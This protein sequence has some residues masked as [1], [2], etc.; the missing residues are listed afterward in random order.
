MLETK[1]KVAFLLVVL[2]FAAL[3]IMG[4]LRGT[5]LTP[6]EEAPPATEESVPSEPETASNEEPIKEEMV[7]IPA[8]PFLRGTMSG[9][10]DEQPQRT[11][12]L[13]TF[14]IDRH[15]VTNYEYQQFV[16]VTGHR[17]AG[18]PSRYAKSIGKMRG[19]NQPVVYVSWDDATEY[20]QWKGKRLPTEASGKRPCVA[21]M[22]G[23]GPGEIK[24]SRAVRTGL[25]C[26]MATT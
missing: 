7:T 2:A 24:K 3:P 16:L 18:P 14:S 19:T 4:I 22:A 17:K 1:F 11:I 15:E 12:Y 25:A 5:T 13:D 9:G 10:F 26:R 21:Q 20:C 23:S 8:G 6:F